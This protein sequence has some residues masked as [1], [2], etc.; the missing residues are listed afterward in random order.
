M[1]SLAQQIIE[2]GRVGNEKNPKS[3]AIAEACLKYLQ[4]ALNPPKVLEGA[5]ALDIRQIRHKAERFV[6]EEDP[7]VAL[8][9]M[10]NDKQVDLRTVYK[11]ARLPAPVVWIEFV[12]ERGNEDAARWGVLIVDRKDRWELIATMEGL[13]H[14]VGSPYMLAAMEALPTDAEGIAGELAW[15]CSANMTE[16]ERMEEFRA[17]I[18]DV[19]SALF[20]L[21]VPRICEIKETSAG[22][23]LQRAREKKGKPPIVEMKKVKLSVGIGR[24]RYKNTGGGHS[25]DHARGTGDFKK[26]LHPV[27]GHLRVYTKRQKGEPLVSWVPH[28][29]RG[30]AELGVVMHERDVVDRRKP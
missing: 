7:S 15:F 27:I 19:M 21:T 28:H 13:T 16:A 17:C 26:R 24:T 4:H 9:D 2:R 25:P 1:T 22:A 30:N 5:H 3:K 11:T 10:V 29:Y 23:R 20:F 14:G 18:I 8:F 6:F 12:P